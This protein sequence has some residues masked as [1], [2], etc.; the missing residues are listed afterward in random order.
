MS[1]PQ[2]GE[3]FPGQRIVVLP[4]RAIARALA[5]PLM[6]GLLPTDIGYFSKAAGHLRERRGGANQA[7]LIYCVKGQGWCEMDGDRHDVRSGD[8]LVVPPKSPHA[9][10]ADEQQ[11]WT[12]FWVHA[13][14]RNIAFLLKELDVTPE[15]PV[16]F[17]G[18]DP[19][20]L[21]LF[22]EVLDV[23]EHG[24]APSHLLYGSQILAHLIGAMIWHRHRSGRHALNANHKVAQSVTFMKQNLAKPLPVSTLAGLANLSASHYAALFKRQMGYAPIDYFIRLKMHESCRLLDT[25]SLSVK[26]I[27]AMVG[28]EDPFYF[29]R[30]FKL[31]NEMSPT[32][33]R[34]MHKG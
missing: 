5:H 33:Y 3:G 1:R 13:T 24:Y 2:K 28:Y 26:E 10:G 17:V 7:I 22:G 4:R 30:V 14:G 16:L 15:R 31:I 27:A 25:T 19:Q 34:L 29:S 20:L 18:Q 6:Q 23:L 8:L 32:E 21:A 11:P 9:Y 12:I